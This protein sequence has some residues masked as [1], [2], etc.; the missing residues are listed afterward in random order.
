ML[1]N[2]GDDPVALSVEGG[3]SAQNKPYLVL[4]AVRVQVRFATF[5]N[6]LDARVQMIGTDQ[7]SG[8][9]SFFQLLR[10]DRECLE[11][12]WRVTSLHACILRARVVA[13]NRPRHLRS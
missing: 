4:T 10:P 6:D 11:L 9:L 13:V 2:L 3:F 12:T 5:G 8:R 7:A 1:A